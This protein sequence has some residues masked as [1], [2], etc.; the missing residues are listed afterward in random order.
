MR[1]RTEIEVG[2]TVLVALVILL[3]GVTWLKEFSL[4]RKVRIWHVTF[5]Q[6]GGL[7]K[8]DE[9]QVNGIRKGSVQAM[10]LA[11]DHVM[12][13]L[14]L[15]REITLTNDCRVAIRSVGLMG[16]RVIAVDL[17][18]T[19]QPYTERDTISGV[20]EMGPAEV[21]GSLGEVVV[22][23]S[24]LAKQLRRVSDSI[25]SKGDLAATVRNFRRA[26]EE[27]KLAVE[28][29]RVALRTTLDNFATA[30]KTTKRLTTDREEQ[31]RKAMD[32][33]SS[34]AAGLERL[35]GRLDSLRAVLQDVTN[36]VD[37]GDG[38][39]GRLV[40]DE[41]LYTDLNQSVQ[42]LK[43]LIQDIRQHPRKYLKFSVF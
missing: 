39:L 21:L 8:S 22:Q 33:F 5:E 34:A 9:V 31:L 28:E 11:G 41:K 15:S 19:G 7:G 37:R 13:D 6:T 26:S 23:V 12:V 25:S 29:N 42:A 35:S 14:A 2:V 27:L 1:R 16:E 38:T 3:W 4:G 30:S 24:A 17:R 40:N 43:A 32:D 10:A 20:F 18:T 36:K